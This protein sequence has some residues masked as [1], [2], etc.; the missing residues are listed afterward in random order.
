MRRLMLSYSR[1]SDLHIEQV[2]KFR[3]AL[4]AE[5]FDVW[6]D[7]SEPSPQPGWPREMEER[8]VAADFVL[9]VCTL[10]YRHRFE[11]EQ[12]PGVGL[13]VAWEA[14]LIRQAIYDA[15]GRVIRFIPV[16]FEPD[17]RDAVPRILR[18][19]RSFRWPQDSAELLALLR[20]P[21]ST[22][23]SPATVA[24]EPRAPDIA[25]NLPVPP[26]RFFSDATARL[27]HLRECC[28]N[29][30][31]RER[32]VA[33]VGLGGVGKT[34]LAAQLAHTESARFSAT[35][36]VRGGSMEELRSS[37]A[38][39]ARPQ[40]LALS[41]CESWTQSQAFF[42]VQQWLCEHAEW[43]LIVDGADGIEVQSQVGQLLADCSAG[44][45][46]V[47]SRLACG[48]ETMMP[49]MELNVWSTAESVAFIRQ[50]SRGDDKLSDAGELAE[51]LGGLPLAL[52]QAMAFV[53]E[54]GVNLRRYIELFA[55]ARA[56]LL[57][58]HTV[59]ATG[60]PDTVAGTWLVSVRKLAA[61]P[62][63][64]LRLSAFLA[65]A[66]L[67]R[68]AI[69]RGATV[70]EIA[71]VL[72][73]R[74]DAEFANRIES[75]PDEFAIEC[76]I[77]ELVRYSLVQADREW[78]MFHPLLHAVEEDR[79]PQ[80]SRDEWEGVALAWVN[81]N[82][83]TDPNEP[84][85]WP[86]FWAMELHILRVIRG[87][88]VLR[89]VPEMTV[90]LMLTLGIFYRA[91]ANYEMAAVL[92]N[93][94][95]HSAEDFLP[96]SHQARTQALHALGWLYQDLGLIDE[97][98][99]VMRLT[100][101]LAEE[102]FGRDS[103]ARGAALNNLG[104]LLVENGRSVEA[105]P[106]LR[107]AVRLV[108]LRFPDGN[109]SVAA[110][111]G[112]LSR[113]LTALERLDEAESLAQQAVAV[114]EQSSGRDEPE[115]AR[116]LVHLSRLRSQSGRHDD[117]EK[118]AC[119]AVRICESVLKPGHPEHGEALT[120]LGMALLRQR[121]FG[122]AEELFVRAVTMFQTAL[123]SRHSS[124]LHASEMLALLKARHQRV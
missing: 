16:L 46:L 77:G 112:N 47:T 92:L 43:L 81:V 49:Q 109:R 75:V 62:R 122:D 73:A 37:M 53:T 65:R 79:T 105:E 100:L 34:Q 87:E 4:V 114:A 39:L 61:L 45:I 72:L 121:R 111:L 14:D 54:T 18:R 21:L 31:P 19:Y 29:A 84:A 24:N 30:Q 51:M 103:E 8:F 119:E 93:S 13:G 115:L 99:Q 80:S 5:S 48:W 60:Y 66:P 85:M 63:I 120:A 110:A 118:L 91:Q 17:T 20:G 117:A 7:H 88:V 68:R 3:R 26:N 107:E 22:R 15:A 94:T 123:P 56:R 11:V 50:R 59:G 58:I 95:L 104:Y 44:T 57:S 25:S 124:V 36:W 41:G 89:M 86:A 78:L 76:A 38:G 102:R 64:V 6:S 2:L 90:R 40:V 52:E 106:L 96:P 113:A 69:I 98:E 55:Q 70:L 35:L 83:P 108:H 9:C 116:Q 74:E 67:P 42:A 27:K 12:P 10:E 23:T 33:L 101:E 71:G 32:A 82:T 28:L 1:E 97:T